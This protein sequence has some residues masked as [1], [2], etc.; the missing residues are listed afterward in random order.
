MGT[1][2]GY[3]PA[4]NSL[5]AFLLYWLPAIL[6]SAGYLARG[7]PKLKA[8]IECRRKADENHKPDCYYPTLTVG[9]VVVRVV[10]IAIPVVN[11][12]AL[13]FDVGSEML[14]RAFS[15]VEDTLDAPLVPKRKP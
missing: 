6:C 7:L 4:W 12:L 9:D 8:E 3:I 13:V 1:L 14:A 15:W 10:V 2:I 5:S 11:I